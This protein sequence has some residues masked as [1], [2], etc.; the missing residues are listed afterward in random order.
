MQGEIQNTV[1]T[2]WHVRMC[3]SGSKSIIFIYDAGSAAT[4]WEW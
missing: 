1:L 3:V 4:I 2:V